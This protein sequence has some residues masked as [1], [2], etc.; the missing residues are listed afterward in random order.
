MSA[1]QEPARLICSTCAAELK[2]GG[3]TVRWA[4]GT[5][6]RMAECS[7]CGKRVP[8][9]DGTVAGKK[10]RRKSGANKK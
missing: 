7:V 6:M 3:F 5:W 9:Q 8:V 4:R 2:A 1:A 10:K